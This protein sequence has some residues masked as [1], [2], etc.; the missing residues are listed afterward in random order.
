MTPEKLDRTI[1]FIVEHQ[2][3]ATVHIEQL[4]VAARTAAEQTRE[5][6]SAIVILTKLAQIQSS[7]LS[8]H[9]EIFQVLHEDLKEALDRLDQILRRLT[10]RN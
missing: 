6:Q 8:R 1:E 2:A 3:Q 10:D 5:M 9:E 7:R 4:A